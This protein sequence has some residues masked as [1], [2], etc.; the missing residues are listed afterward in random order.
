MGAGLPGRS[1]LGL[2]GL[3]VLPGPAP[4]ETLADIFGR[5]I[6]NHASGVLAVMGMTAVPSETASTLVLDTGSESD[7]RYDFQQA[8]LGGGFSIGGQVPVYLEGFAG[9]NRYD[10]TVLLQDGGEPRRL[11]LKWTSIAA[12]GGIRPMCLAPTGWCRWVSEARS[13]SNRPGCRG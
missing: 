3:A 8:Q 11:P 2:M 7:D 4:A 9:Y 5:Q 1:A 12:T 13:T 6:R 10:P